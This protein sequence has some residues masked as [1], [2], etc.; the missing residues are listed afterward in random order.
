MS[1]E[2]KTVD[3]AQVSK[4]VRAY[5]GGRTLSKAER[6][7]GGSKK[8]A[9][10]LTFDDESSAILYVWNAA[11]NYWPVSS[12]ADEDP[13]N[14][15]SDASGLAL[16]KTSH[17]KLDELGVRSPRIFFADDSKA[18]VPA[19]IALVED[20]RGENLEVRLRQEPASGAAILAELAA[21][22]RVMHAHQ[23]RAV[24][25]VALVSEGQAT[26][27]GSCVE[28]IR[29]RA[30]TQLGEAARKVPAIADVRDHLADMVLELAA[31]LRPRQQHALIHGEL[32][33]DHVLIDKD[34]R[35]VVID[36]EGLMFFDAEW[37][38]VF[39]E[40]RFGDNYRWFRVADLEERRMQFFRLALYLSLVAGP[41]RLLEGDFPH[42]AGMM[43]IVEANIPRV[44]KFVS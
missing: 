9:Y 20:L 35:P 21:A 37:E 25:K 13:A 18:I 6:L 30:L 41:L 43:R 7:R 42:R 24:G 27:S 33:P 40:L 1:T 19:D 10:R 14:P 17:Q 4:V 8:G 16:F 31:G 22:I 2:R 11:E 26:E 3:L 44:L 39:L 34:Q 29:N 23:N 28:I 5:G 32:G 38:H 36:I 12:D 15:L